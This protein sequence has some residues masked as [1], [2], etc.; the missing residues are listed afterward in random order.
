MTQVHIYDNLHF[1][2]MYIIEYGR[3]FIRQVAGYRH[4][5]I[6]GRIYERFNS[7][8]STLT[9]KPSALDP[10]PLWMLAVSD[11]VRV[12]IRTQGRVHTPALKQ[13]ESQTN[14]RASCAFDKTNWTTTTTKPPSPAELTSLSFPSSSSLLRLTFPSVQQRGETK[15]KQNKMQLQSKSTTML[16]RR[17]KY[18][19]RR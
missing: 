5:T 8:S 17:P 9:W 10:I 1:S 11:G 3:R 13:T 14:T 18:N 16:W 15:C 2:F 6:H 7:K 12:S 19:T 4:K